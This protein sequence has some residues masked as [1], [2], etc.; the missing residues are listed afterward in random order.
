MYNLKK[1]VSIALL[2]AT[3]LFLNFA[4]ATEQTIATISNDSSQNTYQLIV[5]S[6]EDTQSIKT[7]Y[8]DIFLNGTKIARENLDYHAMINNGMVLEQRDQYIVMKLKSDN[9]DEE[10]G[11]IITVDTLYNGA[12][13]SRK[14]YEIAMAKDQTG[15]TL[16][17]QGKAITKIAIQVNKVFLLGTVG[18][19]NIIMK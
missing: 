19:K 12:N 7:F 11:G 3:T 17:N 10:Q 16:L 18:I 2:L 9:F 14:S 4:F 1:I 5:D 15:W 6:S 13:S 8:K